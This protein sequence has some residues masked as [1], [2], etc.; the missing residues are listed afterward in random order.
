MCIDHVQFSGY[1]LFRTCLNL[2]QA[3]FTRT[4]KELYVYIAHVQI[5]RLVRLCKSRILLLCT[6]SINI[7]IRRILFFKKTSSYK[8]TTNALQVYE[9][10]VNSISK[11]EIRLENIMIMMMPCWK[12]AITFSEA[13]KKLF[14]LSTRFHAEKISCDKK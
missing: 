7:R 14:S 6:I 13:L 10:F 4:P 12:R 3:C 9:L 5:Y 2:I 8:C 11:C 1:L